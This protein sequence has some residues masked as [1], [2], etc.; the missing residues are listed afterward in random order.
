MFYAEDKKQTI[1]NRS[2]IKVL[3]VFDFMKFINGRGLLSLTR[4]TFTTNFTIRLSLNILEKDSPSLERSCGQQI[5]SHEATSLITRHQ[6]MF[7]RKFMF[8]LLAEKVSQ[9]LD[10]KALAYKRL[11]RRRKT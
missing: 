4:G 10:T 8:P 11:E 5:T 2:S 6:N 3:L 1:E 7:S 9:P